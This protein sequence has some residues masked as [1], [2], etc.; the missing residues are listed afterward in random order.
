MKATRF[1]LLALFSLAVLLGGCFTWKDYPI[2]EPEPRLVVNGLFHPDST[3][4][5]FVTSNLGTTETTISRASIR[6]Y[7]V[8]LW[9]PYVSIMG[10]F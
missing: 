10:E 9:I 7:S 1:H 6:E 3:W 2:P 8:L 4:E 5:I